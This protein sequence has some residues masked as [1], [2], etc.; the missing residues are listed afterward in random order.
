MHVYSAASVVS[1]VSPWTLA[2]QASLSMRFPRQ[3][4]WRGLPCLPPE[5]LL[6]PG[7]KLAVL[8]SSALAGVFLPLT[9]PEKPRDE[10]R[11]PKMGG[12]LY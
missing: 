7:I 4:Y 6:N 2:H 12:K 10:N 3:E 9:P 5:A 1:F 11:M 8:T